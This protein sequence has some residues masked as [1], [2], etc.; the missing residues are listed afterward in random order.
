MSNARPFGLFA[1]VLAVG[2]AAAY[3]Q[4]GKNMELHLDAADLPG[5]V[6]LYGSDAVTPLRENMEIATFGGG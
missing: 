4:Q 5:G 6:T 1:V 3:S 2:G